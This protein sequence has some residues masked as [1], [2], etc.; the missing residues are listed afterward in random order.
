[1]STVKVVT[2]KKKSIRVVAS[3]DKNKF[4]SPKDKEMDVRATKAVKVAVEKSKICKK[5]IA[6]YDVKEK[7]AYIESASGVKTYVN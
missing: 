3:G 7:K 4:I 1:M 6:K 5:P 2:G